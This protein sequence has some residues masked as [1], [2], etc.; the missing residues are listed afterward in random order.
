MQKKL[1]ELY[2]LL[3]EYLHNYCKGELDNVLDKQ[4]VCYIL[5]CVFH[6][7]KEKHGLLIRELEHNGYIEQVNRGRGHIL[8]KVLK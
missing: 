7:P 6:V 2:V 1:G 3:L 8:Y 4:N 5:S